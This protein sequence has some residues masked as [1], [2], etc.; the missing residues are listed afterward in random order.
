MANLTR[1]MASLLRDPFESGRKFLLHL[2]DHRKGMVERQRAHPNPFAQYGKHGFSQTDEDGLTLEVVRRIGVSK[3]TFAEFGVG[4][5]TE[6]NTLILL[7]MGWRGFWV[8]VQDLAFD[9]SKSKRLNFYKEWITKDNILPIYRKGMRDLDF[10]EP[11]VVSLDVDG[12]DLHFLKKILESG[13]KPQLFIVEYN[14]RFVPPA[15][16]CMPYNESHAIDGTDYYGAA[17]MNFVD[18]F[19]ENG[20]RLVCCNAASG[21]NAFFVADAHKDKFPEVPEETS[22]I[23]AAPLV[24][25]PKSIRTIETMISD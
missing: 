8:G 7:A 20:F 13:N 16:F 14:P 4:D 18:V 11:D 5:G 17:L 3:G 15:R 21:I 22:K 2:T 6:N 23:F 10:T 25:H 12:N 9:A 19:E 24:H 1:K